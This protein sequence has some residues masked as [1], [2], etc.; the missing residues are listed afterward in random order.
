MTRTKHLNTKNIVLMAMFAAISIVL[1]RYASFV[2]LDGTIRIGFGNLP[3]ILSGLLLGPVAGGIVGAVSDLFG[4]MLMP[5]G[6]Y[7]PGL[8]ISAALCGIIPGIIV[9]W[10]GKKDS[11]LTNVVSNL[12]ICIFIFYGLNTLWISQLYGKAFIVLLPNRIISSSI[13]T[14]FHI[15][16]IQILTR[17]LKKFV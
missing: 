4:M 16:F 8:T 15:I 13:I 14:A 11:F 2:F 12:I 5:S 9:Y 7:H 17:I 3:I 6:A 10:T 1:T